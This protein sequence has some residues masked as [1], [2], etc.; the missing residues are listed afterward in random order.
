MD[1]QITERGKQ[2]SLRKEFD[3]LHD[4]L[5]FLIQKEGPRTKTWVKVGFISHLTGWKKYELKRAREQGLIKMKRTDE[6]V[7]Y[8]LES[9]DKK[10]IIVERVENR[11]KIAGK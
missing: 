2:I 3:R 7:F 1:S 10:F 8:L 9:L 4:K 5:N 11:P 6:G